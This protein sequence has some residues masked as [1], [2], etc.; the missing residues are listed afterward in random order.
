M[1]A[2]VFFSDS[3]GNTLQLDLQLAIGVP[4]T[5]QAGSYRL[6]REG[7]QESGSVRSRSV[8]FLGG[9]SDWPNLGGTFELLQD[10]AMKYLVRFDPTPVEP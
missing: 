6:H 5:L 10:G 8:T 7:R 1:L 2:G 9:Q 4:T 3:A